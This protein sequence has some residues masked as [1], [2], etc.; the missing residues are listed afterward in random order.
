MGLTFT[1]RGPDG[2][3]SHFLLERASRSGRGAPTRVP[4]SPPRASSPHA[5]RIVTPALP[6]LLPLLLPPLCVHVSACAQA[7]AEHDLVVTSAA[8][9]SEAWGPFLIATALGAL[10]ST[11]SA[12]Q[13]VVHAAHNAAHPYAR[14]VLLPETVALV[15]VAL[16]AW[17]GAARVSTPRMLNTRGVS[18]FND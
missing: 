6:L 3:S 16:I 1:P 7:Q 4:T 9:F 14:R 13:Y 12:A 11:A 5:A 2:P 10:L 8:Y 17:G 15:A 18:S